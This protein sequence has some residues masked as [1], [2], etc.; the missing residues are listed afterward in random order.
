M[1]NEVVSQYLLIHIHHKH[2]KNDKTVLGLGRDVS[3]EA[4]YPC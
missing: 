3:N 2:L 4:R 1:I